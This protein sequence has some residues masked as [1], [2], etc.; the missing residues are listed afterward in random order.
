MSSIA[1]KLKPFMVPGFVQAEMPPGKRQDG[2]AE[3]PSFALADLSQ[4]ALDG[5][6]SDWLDALYARANKK[7]KWVRS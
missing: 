1:L 5:L 6:A 3:L 7:H 4:E 2:I